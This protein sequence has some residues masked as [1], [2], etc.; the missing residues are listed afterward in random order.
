VATVVL[1][2]DVVISFLEPTDAL[3]ER[4]I[5]E[6]RPWLSM[7]H[8][9]LLPTVAYAEAL[10]HPLQQDAAQIVED[11]VDGGFEL[12]AVDRPIARRA[13]EIRARFGI[14]LVDAVVIATAVEHGAEL[15]TFD[16]RMTVVWDRMP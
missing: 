14:D 10:V 13:A 9:R 4:S 11:F 7:E 2:A 3:H 16:A 15:V 12:V 8:R 5:E 1:D 6:V